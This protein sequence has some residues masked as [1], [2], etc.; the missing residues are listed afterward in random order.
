MSSLVK[1][2]GLRIARCGFGNAIARFL[3][4]A[5]CVLI[6]HHSLRITVAA[7]SATATLSGTVVDQ[8]GAAIPGVA[9]TV[10][11]AGTSLQREVASNDKGD[12]VVPL[13]S[14]GTYQIRARRDGFAQL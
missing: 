8:N 3:L 13:L 11:N 7:Q 14:P 5:V 9:I 10:L 6:T 1:N 12:F 2:F 4:I